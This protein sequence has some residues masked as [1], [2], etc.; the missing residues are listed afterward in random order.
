MLALLDSPQVNAVHAVIEKLFLPAL[1]WRFPRDT[2]GNKL[3]GRT[4]VLLYE[5]APPSHPAGKG[6]W[7]MVDRPDPRA[8]QTLT[9]RLARAV[10]WGATHRWE[11]MPEYWRITPGAPWRVRLTDE[12]RGLLTDSA[13]RHGPARLRH[14]GPRHLG[15]PYCKRSSAAS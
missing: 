13:R 12:L 4:Q 9:I 1:R 6:V 3:A 10:G 2:A 8:E 11:S 14:P 7:L 5:C 15:R